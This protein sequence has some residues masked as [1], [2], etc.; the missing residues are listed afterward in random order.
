MVQPLDTEGYRDSIHK[1]LPSGRAWPEE[2]GT[3][4]DSLVEAFA[5]QMA[6][7]DVGAAAMLEEVRPDTTFDLLPDWERILG[8][9]DSCSVLGS[10]FAIRR[11]SMLTKLIAQPTQNA[12]GY[13]AIAAEFGTTISIREHDQTRADAIAGLDTTNGRWRYV[14]WIDIPS[15]ADFQEW[16]VLSDVTEALIIVERNTELECRLQDAAP[17]H[18]HLIIAYKASLALPAVADFSLGRDE[19]TTLP[20]ATGGTAPY[21]YSV[22]GLPTDVTFNQ[23]IRRLRTRA[24][25]PLGTFTLTYMVEDADGAMVSRS[26]ELTVVP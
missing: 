18:T 3:A 19:N 26:F 20:E 6:E 25:T 11:A 9:P 1:L 12:S 17:A 2:T 4:L 24:S 10:T 8:L 13:R 7:I 14:W 15:D 21:T 23:N 5:A 16:S 22:T